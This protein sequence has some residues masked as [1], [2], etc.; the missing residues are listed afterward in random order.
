MPYLMEPLESVDTY[1]DEN[2][3]VSCVAAGVPRPTVSWYSNG[4]LLQGLS[5]IDFLLHCLILIN[6]LSTCHVTVK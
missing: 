1:E 6:L 5:S 2:I 3:T 4:R